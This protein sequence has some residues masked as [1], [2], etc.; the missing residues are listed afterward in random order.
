MRR[1]LN[2]RF[3]SANILYL[4]NALHGNKITAFVGMGI[5][6]DIFSDP[7]Q[8]LEFNVF[9]QGFSFVFIS[10]IV[11]GLS[12]VLIAAEIIVDSLANGMVICSCLPSTLNMVMVLTRI[13][14][15]DENA[16]IYNCTFGTI[17]GM[18]VGPVLM[19]VYLSPSSP[20]MDVLKVFYRIL[21]RVI[22]PTILGQ[23]LQK[24][25][26]LTMRFV[27]RHRKYVMYGQQLLLTFVV[28]TMFCTTFE[29]NK[30][31]DGSYDNV[32]TYRLSSHELV[33]ILVMVVIQS[34]LLCVFKV[35]SWHSLDILYTNEPQLR[36]M[37]IF[38]CTH[39]SVSFKLFPCAHSVE[40]P[41]VT[42]EQAS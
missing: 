35:I 3:C 14:G 1:L 29:Q 6:T 7:T 30:T 22:V 39:K 37:G 28:Y 10:A 13:S 24:Q 5:K 33:S 31:E 12:R 2:N 42:F 11:Y 8:R 41:H 38:G 19:V 18:I 20:D 4:N 21:V 25:S 27:R 26:K 34:L 36:C 23:I 40:I 15:G 16:A 17:I 32:G 9:V